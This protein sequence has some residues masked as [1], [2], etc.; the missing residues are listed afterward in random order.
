M[1]LN[2]GDPGAYYPHSHAKCFYCRGIFFRGGA[3]VQWS[4]ESGLIEMHPDCALSM[5]VRLISDIHKAQCEG[6]ATEMCGP[7]GHDIHRQKTEAQP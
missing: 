5:C 3:R 1:S 4:G 6:L 7:T 2:R